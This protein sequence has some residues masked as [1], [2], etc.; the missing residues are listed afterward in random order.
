MK[1]SRDEYLSHAI[2]KLRNQVKIR[3]NRNQVPFIIQNYM[4]RPISG[5]PQVHNLCLEHIYL[6]SYSFL[7]AC[8]LLIVAQR[9]C[10]GVAA[11]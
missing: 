10:I 1:E 6:D 11:R 3:P 5:H 4:L 2:R 7:D 9:R 8:Y